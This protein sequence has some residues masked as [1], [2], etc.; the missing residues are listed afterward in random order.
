MVELAGLVGIQVATRNK[1]LLSF[2]VGNLCMD[3]WEANGKWFRNH[4]SEILTERNTCLR[5]IP[6][7]SAVIVCGNDRYIPYPHNCATIV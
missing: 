2:D 3:L 1:M 5:V 6:N 7:P 4:I